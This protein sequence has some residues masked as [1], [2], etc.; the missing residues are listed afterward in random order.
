MQYNINSRNQHFTY[1]V[2]YFIK[3]KFYWMEGSLL[4]FAISSPEG[5]FSFHRISNASCYIHFSCWGNAFIISFF[6][7][8]ISYLKKI[9]NYMQF[10]SKPIIKLKLNA[11]WKNF[12]FEKC[13]IFRYFVSWLYRKEDRKF[14]LKLKKERS[15]FLHRRPSLLL[16]A[17]EK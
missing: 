7:R 17:L 5:A 2:K 11:L 10:P 13:S 1:V 15:L 12:T 4:S 6:S 9:S 3:K 8:N 14:N 16:K